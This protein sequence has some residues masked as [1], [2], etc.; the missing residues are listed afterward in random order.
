[1]KSNREELQE[2]EKRL[3]HEKERRMFERYQTIRL[4]MMGLCVR[5]ESNAIC[6]NSLV[7]LIQV[8]LCKTSTTYD[9]AHRNASK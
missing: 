3:K 1:M 4:Y 5:M 2:V 7:H 9:K 6:E 8:V